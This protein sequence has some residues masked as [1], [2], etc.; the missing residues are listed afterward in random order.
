MWQK[1]T[2]WCI[3]KMGKKKNYKNRK[4]GRFRDGFAPLS[5]VQSK[6]PKVNEEKKLE[7]VPFSGFPEIELLDLKLDYYSVMRGIN[8]VFNPSEDLQRAVGLTIVNTLLAIPENIYE[9]G[10]EH[11]RN[12]RLHTTAQLEDYKD[13]L[14][15]LELKFDGAWRGGNF[16]N[17]I[18]RG[19]LDLQGFENV[20]YARAYNLESAVQSEF[21]EKQG[22]Y[23]IVFLD[24]PKRRW[25]EEKDLEET[26]IAIQERHLKR[27]LELEKTNSKI[28]LNLKKEAEEIFIGIAEKV[29][30]DYR[31]LVAAVTDYLEKTEIK[32][33]LKESL[34]NHLDRYKFTEETINPELEAE[35]DKLP[36][37]TPQLIG[38]FTPNVAENGVLIIR[39][40][41]M[42]SCPGFKLVE[43][44]SSGKETVSLYQRED[45]SHV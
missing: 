42:D 4:K 38:R 19:E 22:N 13:V 18:E 15:V 25:Y 23:D 26:A 2:G 10:K 37:D 1:E 31:I 24:Q 11:P 5:R 3:K 45:S 28:P 33:K 35:K 41:Q 17:F 8:S 34:V 9:P 14:K 6:K 44:Y 36:T 30:T 21:Y 20:D 16:G 40:Y 32:D 39:G 43:T 27:I 29:G 12:E 7:V